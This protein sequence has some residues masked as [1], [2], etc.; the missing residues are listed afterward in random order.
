MKNFIILLIVALITITL[1]LVLFRPDLLEGIWLWL[2]GLSGTIIGFLREG[3][4]SLV[5]FIKKFDRE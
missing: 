1:M 5:K 3:A 4:K 2:I